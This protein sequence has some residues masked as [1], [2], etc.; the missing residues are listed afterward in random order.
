MAASLK[1]EL[2][3]LKDRLETIEGQLSG[4]MKEIEERESKWK[5]LDPVID[6]IVDSQNEIVKL[7]VG[8]KRFSTSVSTLKKVKG[9]F[10]EKLLSS[11]KVDYNE[12]IF[13]DRSPQ[14]FPY[15]LDYLRTN[16]ID[17]K[18]FND[19]QLAILMDDAEFFGIG[20][21]YQDLIGRFE[22]IEFVDFEQ[23]KTYTYGG[24]TAG[25]ARLKDLQNKNM[26][27]GICS[28]A[29]GFIIIELNHEY[30]INQLEVGGF[31]G[32][33]SL[34]SVEN[35]AG[36]GIYTSTDR[37][38][39]KR[40]GE[41]PSGYGTTI[42]KV[43]LTTSRAHYIKFESKSYVGIGYLKLFKSNQDKI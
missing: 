19:D 43:K 38:K 28:D 24:K 22:E 10:F 7:N 15:L 37:T 17:Y 34:W 42:A 35:G 39:W 25:T 8:G 32:N 11:G 23:G 1:D 13:F 5:R 3:T 27:G 16:Q 12:E 26:K 9:S 31:R 2:I 14:V 30:E 21:V 33:P 4:Q 36:A 6:S 18:K 41:I 20:K 29:P 40:V